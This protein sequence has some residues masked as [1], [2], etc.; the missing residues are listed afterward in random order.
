[1]MATLDPFYNRVYQMMTVFYFFY[2]R[3]HKIAHLDSVLKQLHRGRRVRWRERSRMGNRHGGGSALWRRRWALRWA[4]KYNFG[5]AK[6]LSLSME[7]GQFLVV[8]S[9]IS[10]FTD[11]FNLDLN[12]T[13]YVDW[14]KNIINFTTNILNINLISS[15]V[16]FFNF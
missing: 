2:Q 9:Y 12:P 1:M 5:T 8:D 13:Y 14:K 7:E 16:M 3:A 6:F 11:V 4:C 15:I 10:L